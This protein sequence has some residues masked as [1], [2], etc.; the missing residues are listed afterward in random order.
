MA[1]LTFVAYLKYGIA[2]NR[3]L[4]TLLRSEHSQSRESFVPKTQ[5]SWSVTQLGTVTF[6]FTERDLRNSETK[7]V[8]G[9]RLY[10]LAYQVAVDLFSERGDIEFRCSI[11]GK[12]KGK[13]TIQFQQSFDIQH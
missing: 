1:L 10:K 7:L 12:S 6:R 11:D 13:G 9:R 5:Y 4:Q 2:T 3:L 8:D